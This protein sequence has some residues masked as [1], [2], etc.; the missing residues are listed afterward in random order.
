VLL[1]GFGT[2][3]THHTLNTFRWGPDGALYFNQGV[4]IKSTVETPFGPRRLFGGGVWR[5]RPDRLRLEVH[6]RSILDNNTWGHA[7]DAW[8][9]SLLASAWP[10]GIN[11][12]LPDSPLH[13]G[14]DRD[15][16]PP[17]ALTRIGGGRHCGL[18]VVGGRH[19]PDDWQGDLLTG[20][21]LTHRI[22]RFR[23]NEDAGRLAAAPLPP[24]V[25]SRSPTFRPVD[26][27][28]GPDGALYVADLHQE[29]IQHN[30]IDFRDPRRDHRHGRVWRIVRTDR[31]LLPR[32]R[33][34]G[35]P[36]AEVLD[37]LKDPEPWTRA[38]AKRA[39]AE[40]DR[41][42]VAA[43]LSASVDRLDPRDPRREHHLLEALWTCQTIDEVNA[44]LLTRLLHA[45]EPRARAAATRVLGAWSDRLPDAVRL[46]RT[47]AAYPDPRVRLEAVL[48][49]A[50]IP[51]ADAAQAALTVLEGPPDPLVEDAL[52]RMLLLLKPYWYPEFRAGR[53]TF[54]HPRALAFVLKSLHTPDAV[55]AVAELLRAGKV[56]REVRA[57]V[58]CLLAAL[59]DASH[60]ALALDDALAADRLDPA[61]RV[62]VL[63]ALAQA[64]RARPVRPPH[65]ERLSLLFG[66]P[67]ASLSAAALRLAGAWKLEEL[68]GELERLAGSADAGP[69]R[70]AAVEALVGLGGPAS[71]R[72]LDALAAG[73]QPYAVRVEAAAGLAVLDL[74]QAAR[75]AASLLRLPVGPGEDP[76]EV[77]T[78]FLHRAGGP[79][80]LA[81]ALERERPSADAA[82]VGLRVV[83]G[84]GV[85][86][87][88]LVATLQA[89]AGVAGQARTLDAEGLR[90]LL[91][92]V[93]TGG[94]PARG[95]AVFRRPELSCL[96]CHAIAGAGGRVGPDLATVG[97]SA[98]PD[99]LAESILAPG[100][101]V[102]DGYATAHVITTDGR[103]LSGVV[104]RESPRELVL[105]DPTRDEIVVPVRD[106]E[107]RQNGGSL[108]PGGLDQTL[109]DAELADLVRFLSELGR[110]GPYAPLHVQAARRWQ[111]LA[112]PPAS[113]LSLGDA[114]LGRALCEDGNLSWAPAYSLVSGDFPLAEVAAGGGKTALV[115]CQVEVDTPGKVELVL[116][117]VRGLTLWVDGGLVPARAR[118]VLEL[119]P[120]I[121]TLALR[122]EGGNRLRCELA[123]PAGSP[124]RASFVGGR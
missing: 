115:R 98:P 114:A 78:A 29:I 5:M 41:R 35:V 46:L 30:Q 49:A 50:R 25:V 113:L 32:P 38:Q 42:E 16:V 94:D 40:R 23:L 92:R 87:P 19:F 69:R 47:Q 10:D 74:K 58:L 110:P 67:D 27:K 24:L 119:P 6:D 21:F 59:G 116:G 77:F 20:D 70:R 39:L 4:Y 93:R 53:L 1:T 105:R 122:V 12:L 48:A 3:D 36:V 95:E 13:Q 121:H 55:P 118:S 61:G 123:V 44:P 14:E 18:E 22:Q 34:V 83:R 85:P 37:H 91:D 84:L 89:A 90:R 108:M 17:L 106:I 63:E 43:A 104:V 64:A 124:A 99:Y 28:L 51:S 7:F 31:P 80:A 120:G 102:K 57:D 52:R 60:S 9:R 107:E 79:A 97:A 66:H 82:R 15:L 68:R 26:V 112:A 86:A 54:E 100:K 103:A 117:D 96:G 75:Q 76:S 33:L 81:G 72:R 8:G 11:L 2:Q 101:V 88:P 45:D 65:P 109:T 73:G 111:Y 62:R 56:P 71:V